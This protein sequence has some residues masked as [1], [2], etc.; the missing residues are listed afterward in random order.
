MSPQRIARWVWRVLYVVGAGCLA[1]G[2]VTAVQA[3]RFV[4]R[5]EHGVGT[6][7]GMSE[8]RDEEGS[9]TT[10]PIVRFTTADGRRIKFVSSTWSSPPSNSPGDR[11]EVLYEPGDPAGARLNGFFDLW[12]LPLVLVPMAALFF[13]FAWLLRRIMR[14]RKPEEVAWLLEHGRRLTG[15]SPRVITDASIDIQG[16]SPFRVDVD[17]H[18]PALNEVRVLSSERLWF[19]PTP[20]LAGRES[21]DVFVD[22]ERPRRYL[23]DLSFLP[24]AGDA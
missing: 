14:G 18:D 20:F 10:A 3:A 11:V 6:V 4:S 23:V 7:V 9:V 12:L 8:K 1:G 24:R 15:G 22:P 13:G 2:V 17:V 21:V 5:A 16:R 19:D